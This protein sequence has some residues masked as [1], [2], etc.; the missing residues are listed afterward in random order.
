VFQ[1]E[2]LDE[3]ASQQSAYAA[4]YRHGGPNFAPGNHSKLTP[5]ETSPA[6]LD[7]DYCSHPA[8][9]RCLVPSGVHPAQRLEDDG[10]AKLK[11]DFPRPARPED[12]LQAQGR[13]HDS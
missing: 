7:V 3:K 12:S 13:L 2:V 1:P 8:E 4:L 6:L 11:I 10:C 5:D 9:L